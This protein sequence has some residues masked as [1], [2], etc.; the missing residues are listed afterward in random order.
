M[1]AKAQIIESL[2]SHVNL[3]ERKILNNLA[4]SPNIVLTVKQF[5]ASSNSFS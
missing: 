1:N 5:A 4:F 3:Q 2:C